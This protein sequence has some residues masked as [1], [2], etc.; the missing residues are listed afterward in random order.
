MRWVGHVTC[1]Q[2][3]EDRC[4]HSLGGETLRERGYLEDLGIDGG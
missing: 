3:R 1:M 4:I 2:E